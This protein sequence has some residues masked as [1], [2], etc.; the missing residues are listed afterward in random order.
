M[1]E[2]V[3]LECESCKSKNYRTPMETQGGG[4]LNLRKYCK[5]CGKHTKHASKKK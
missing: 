1:R 5:F 3:T 2:W 4:K